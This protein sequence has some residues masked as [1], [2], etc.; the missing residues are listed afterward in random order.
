[1]IKIE[2]LLMEY[3]FPLFIIELIII[4]QVVVIAGVLELFGVI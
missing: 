2:R 4:L 1:M 3:L